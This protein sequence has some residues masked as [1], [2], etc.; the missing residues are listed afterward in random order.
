VNEAVEKIIKYWD[1]YAP[2]FDQAHATENLDNWREVLRTLI[3]EGKKSVLDLGTGTGFLAKMAAELGYNSTG[4]DLSQKMMDLGKEVYG[5]ELDG[6]LP[7][8]NAGKDEMVSA[9]EEAGFIDCEA[10]LLPAG[11][12]IV[13]DMNPW[14]AIK[15]I[16]S[17]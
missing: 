13:T 1:D 14:Y 4:V 15:G 9:L 10:I 8:K 6:Q 2:E 3:G 17:R 11:L 12:T 16:K 5:G 7:L